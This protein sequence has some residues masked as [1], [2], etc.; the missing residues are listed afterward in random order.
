MVVNL[1]RGIHTHG[2]RAK[3]ATASFCLGFCENEFERFHGMLEPNKECE[4]LTYLQE[5]QTWGPDYFS[6]QGDTLQGNSFIQ[7]LEPLGIQRTCIAFS[8]RGCNGNSPLRL[9]RSSSSS[10]WARGVMTL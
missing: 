1:G 10:S 7:G 4:A 9:H 2:V 5:N 3:H 8:L 6:D